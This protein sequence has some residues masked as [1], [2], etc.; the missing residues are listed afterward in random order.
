[1]NFI[2]KQHLGNLSNWQPEPDS[3]YCDPG[4]LKRLLS[5]Y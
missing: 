1:M 3:N 2:L 4:F 5:F